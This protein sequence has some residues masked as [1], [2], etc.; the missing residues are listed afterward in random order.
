MVIAVDVEVNIS[1]MSFTT[2]CGNEIKMHFIDLPLT[3][4]AVSVAIIGQDRHQR[5]IREVVDLFDG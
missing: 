4:K 5:L 1:D 2:S 3:Q